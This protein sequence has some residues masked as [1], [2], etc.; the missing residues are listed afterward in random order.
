MK[1]Y[2]A[3]LIVVAAL[4]LTRTALPQSPAPD[5]PVDSAAK[6]AIP[7]G[8]VFY[9][10]LPY[11]IRNGRA[12]LIDATL[13]PQGQ[14]LT[15]EGKLAPFPSTFTAFP[16]VPVRKGTEQQTLSGAQPIIP[17]ETTNT[18]PVAKGTDQQTLI[19][20]PR[21]TTSKKNGSG[22]LLRK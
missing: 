21:A 4:S 19:N 7:N 1:L 12:S 13:V 2:L 5:A 17:A 14:I 8:V 10:G 6:A 9:N 18:T 22:A 15:A 11:L 3:P 20:P 16:S